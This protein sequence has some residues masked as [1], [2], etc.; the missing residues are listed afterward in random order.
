MSNYGINFPIKFVTTICC[1]KI[2]PENL[3]KSQKRV[4]MCENLMNQT[5]MDFELVKRADEFVKNDWCLFKNLSSQNDDKIQ[6]LKNNL[7]LDV[8]WKQNAKLLMVVFNLFVLLL[9]YV[10][11]LQNYYWSLVFKPLCL[12]FL[13]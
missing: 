13:L 12:K 9:L 7:Q 1:W 6:T 10:N 8:N 2:D 4:Q 11:K 5:L 3:S